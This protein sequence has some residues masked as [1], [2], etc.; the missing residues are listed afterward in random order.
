MNATAAMLTVAVK[1][2][3]SAGGLRRTSETSRWQL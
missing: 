3:G 2:T 1:G